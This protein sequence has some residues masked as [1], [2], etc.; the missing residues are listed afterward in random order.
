LPGGYRVE[1]REGIS[2]YTPGVGVQ[3]LFIEPGSPCENGYVENITGIMRAELLNRE[4]FYTLNEARAPGDVLIV[5]MNKDCSVK[6]FKPNHPVQNEAD[7]ARILVALRPVDY[8]VMFPEETPERLIKLVKPDFLVKGADYENAEI[9]GA[10]FVTSYG[11]K[12]KRIKLSKGRST[13][14]IIKKIKKL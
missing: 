8:V 9:V 14:D 3:A 13:S 6:K 12:V 11:G 5:G 10:D 1:L 2:R 4:I 7:R